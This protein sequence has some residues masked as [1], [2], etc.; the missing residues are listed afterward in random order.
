MVKSREDGRLRQTGGSR[1]RELGDPGED[2][3]PRAGGA[4]RAGHQAWG[5]HEAQSPGH[6][7]QGGG[8]RRDHQHGRVLDHQHQ[9]GANKYSVK[10]CICVFIQ[11][12]ASLNIDTGDPDEEGFAVNIIFE[13]FVF[14]AIMNYH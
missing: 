9:G 2:P 8:A 4:H 1:V 10:M 12:P 7:R 5:E 11:A 3:D 13:I 6:W 14:N